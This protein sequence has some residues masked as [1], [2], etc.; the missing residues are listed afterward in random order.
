MFCE[1]IY[2][3]FGPVSVR[4]FAFFHFSVYF[5]F[6]SLC[7]RLCVCA[8]AVVFRSMTEKTEMVYN[9]T[10]NLMRETLWRGIS[11]L[12]RRPN[13]TLVQVN[14]CR[15][16]APTE[17][18]LRCRSKRWRLCFAVY[19]GSVRFSNAAA[20][21]IYVLKKGIWCFCRL[22]RCFLLLKRE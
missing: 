10:S 18:V 14:R 22:L 21:H 11:D 3:L 12:I 16:A 20:R 9:A 19:S 7:V 8:F 17:I 2:F 6:F 15:C 4:N 13:L 1:C 5:F